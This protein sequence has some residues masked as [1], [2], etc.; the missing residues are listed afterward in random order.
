MEIHFLDQFDYTF[1][2]D[3]IMD[4][5][6][7]PRD[8]V[9]RKTVEKVL[10]E[11]ECV[12][13]PKAFYMESK[14]Q[15][16]TVDSITIGGQTFHSTALVKNLEGQDTVFPFLC[17]C[18]RELLEFGEGLTDLMEQYAFDC[19]MEFYLR[20]AS[21]A[22]TGALANMED[23][24]QT[25]SVNPGSLVD[26]PIEEQQEL[27][28]LFGDNASLIGVELSDSCIMHP[29]KSVSGIRYFTEE[30]FHNCQ[31]CQRSKCPTREAD[32]DLELYTKTLK[33]C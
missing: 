10:A 4:Q 30:E 19:I 7:M 8:H 2:A 17:T 1:T 12:A 28:A 20:K 27:F 25:S 24:R 13:K 5:L 29:M 15:E 6:G 3:D 9:F 22:L 26:W 16:R 18:G 11:A 14:I 32:F 21:V 23:G 31:L 33:Q